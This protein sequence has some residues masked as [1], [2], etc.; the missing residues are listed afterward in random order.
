MPAARDSCAMHAPRP[1]E[2]LPEFVGRLRSV[3]GAILNVAAER[4][5]PGPMQAWLGRV[6]DW[7][8]V[9]WE[10]VAEQLTR[11]LGFEDPPYAIREAA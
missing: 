5:L 6:S 3:L 1:G 11:R 9:D 8:A 4:D 2:S 7:T 10:Q